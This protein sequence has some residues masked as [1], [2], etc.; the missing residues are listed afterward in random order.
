MNIVC[1]LQNWVLKT[2]LIHYINMKIANSIKRKEM[3]F[4]AENKNNSFFGS[5]NFKPKVM[6]VNKYR[7]SSQ[8][9]IKFIELGVKNW[10]YLQCCT[11]NKFSNF[12]YSEKSSVPFVNTFSKHLLEY[13]QNT[14][15][16]VLQTSVQLFRFLL[17]F[18][19]H[20]TWMQIQVF[21]DFKIKNQ[22]YF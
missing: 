7:L 10:L 19:H 2:S 1:D 9:Q 15:V 14:F 6:L 18:Y 5:C 11:K 22:R 20:F 4:I 13:F 12:S 21:T 8:K 3:K 17:K 16:Q